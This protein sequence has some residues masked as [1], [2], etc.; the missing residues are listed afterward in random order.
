AVTR[1]SARHDLLAL[2]AVGVA[3]VARAQL[4]VLAVALAVAVVAHGRARGHRVLVAGYSLGALALLILVVAGRNP[5]GTYATTARG[6][7]LPLAVFPS[8][9][10][11]LASVGLGIGLLPFILGGAWLV[12]RARR[13]A[14]ATL[15]VTAIV[16][17]TVEVT[18]YDIRFG[19]GLVRDRYVFYLAPVF[20]IAFAAALHACPHPRWLVA[21]VALLAVGLALEPLPIFGKLSVDTPV[22]VF[23]NYLRAS[24][25]GLTGARIFLAAAAVISGVLVLEARAL[26]TRRAF[27]VTV[28]VIVL[29]GST[30]AT[31]YTFERLFAVDG[32]AGRPL[33]TDPGQVQSWVDRAVGAGAQVTAVPFPTNVGEYWSNAAYWWDVE[34]WNKSVK[35]V[36]GV[37]G[38]FEWTPST[39]PKLALR[40]DEHGAASVSPA[41]Y[42]MQAVGDTRFHIAGTVVLNNRNV[43]LVR[44][45]RPWHADWSTSGLYEDGW[46]RPGV[47]AHVHV[48]PYPGQHGSVTRSLT[49]S[50]FAPAGV[51]TRTFT[52]GTAAAAA[53]PNE[54]SQKISVCVAPAR[55]TSVALTV[56]G[57]SPIPRDAGSVVALPRAGGV[58]ISRIYVSGSVT[59]GCPAFHVRKASSS[60]A[61]ASAETSSGVSVPVSSIVRRN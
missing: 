10:A 27:V 19:G 38:E 37:P 26:L 14:F 55:P 46:T 36:A 30:S 7:P 45:G 18:S 21:P 2:A 53:G 9:L 51:A 8:L 32:T 22:S 58:Q 54:V 52:L 48:Y 35:L 59:P 24:L 6:N 15:A 5:L 41:G 39:F 50:V 16:L 20:A 29:A 11:H 12:A 44:P 60:S 34:F 47:T 56:D 57:A 31:A 40:F 33:T 25:G 3:V 61:S 17:L 43:F 23:D 28:A 49:V 13:D 4:G 1:P 42:V